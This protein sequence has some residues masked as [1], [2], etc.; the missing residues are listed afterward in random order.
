MSTHTLKPGLVPPGLSPEQ[1]IDIE[2][3]GIEHSIRELA[4]QRI[5]LKR[6]RNSF[7]PVCKMPF[8][9][10]SRIFELAC[11]PKE[12][13]WEWEWDVKKRPT[14]LFLGTICSAWRDVTLAAP[15]LWSYIAV[16]FDTK[17]IASELARV[18]YWLDRAADLPLSIR[19]MRAEHGRSNDEILE[20]S[21]ALVKRERFWR[22]FNGYLPQMSYERQWDFPMLSIL[23]LRGPNENVS[24]FISQETFSKAPL[25]RNV[26]L[27][28]CYGP[29]FIKL[30][31]NQL[32]SIY[33]GGCAME[34]CVETLRLCPYL[35]YSRFGS[36]HRYPVALPLPYMEHIHHD[37]LQLLTLY[38]RLNATE[39]IAL[40]NSF[41]LPSLL[42]LELS[43]IT[44]LSLDLIPSLVS[45]SSCNLKTLNLTCDIVEEEIIQCLRVLPSLITLSLAHPR[46]YRQGVGVGEAFLDSLHPSTHK[47]SLSSPF[48]LVPKL[49]HFTYLG[50]I[51]FSSASLTDFLSCRWRC[52]H[53]GKV[54][55]LLRD[56]FCDSAYRQRCRSTDVCETIPVRGNAL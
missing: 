12:G 51:G 42:D 55:C 36:V 18:R 7:M 41:T 4:K 25:L 49:Q 1:E 11:L 16:T 53:A 43:L 20:V 21:R 56:Y 17:K 38:T 6:R 24:S 40:V 50:P 13:A 30:P 52:G 9:L 19:I 45:R 22:S 8:E 39:F 37:N 31:Y 35:R 33:V 32:E 5:T 27:S 44:N 10:L 14:P 29:E 54:L 46:Y 23:S 26:T 15:H 3:A 47:R 48:C 2:I 34:R 28:G